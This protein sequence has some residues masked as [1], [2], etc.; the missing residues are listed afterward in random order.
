MPEPKFFLYFDATGKRKLSST[1]SPYSNALQS[2]RRQ[3]V[4]GLTTGLA[5][6]S[7]AGTK[8]GMAGGRHA[9]QLEVAA[10]SGRGKLRRRAG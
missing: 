9:F 5:R 3:P 8:K 1:E 2:S 7:E 4:G 10:V 6:F